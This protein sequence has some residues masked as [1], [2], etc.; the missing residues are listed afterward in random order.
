MLEEAGARRQAQADP[1]AAQASILED[2]DQ[3]D[4][5]TIKLEFEGRADRA[6]DPKEI[7][8]PMGLR[9]ADQA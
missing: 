5:A 2:V 7:P 3:K 8:P 9:P 4:S 6:D 1:G